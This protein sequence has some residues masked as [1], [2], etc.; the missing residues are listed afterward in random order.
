MRE[1]GSMQQPSAELA[2]LIHQFYE[3]E[4]SGGLP[5][6]ARRFFSYQQGVILIGYNP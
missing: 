6:V 1:K 2:A 4:T 3:I 5:A